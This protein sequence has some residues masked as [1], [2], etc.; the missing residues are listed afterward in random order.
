MNVYLVI[1]AV[2]CLI[3]GVVAYRFGTRA[4][5]QAIGLGGLFLLLVVA[6]ALLSNYSPS[7]IYG[8]IQLNVD[9][10]KADSLGLIQFLTVSYCLIGGGVLAALG[11]SLKKYRNK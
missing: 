3:I 7:T 1:T 4:S 6:I 9:A 10:I 2:G 11:Y 8:V 5:V